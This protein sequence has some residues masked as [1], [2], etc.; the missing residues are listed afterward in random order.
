MRR[1]VNHISF[2][3]IAL[4]L[5]QGCGSQNNNNTQGNTQAN[6]RDPIVQQSQKDTVVLK[7]TTDNNIPVANSTSNSPATFSDN[8]ITVIYA[9]SQ[10]WHGGIKGSGGGTN[11]EICVVPSFSSAQLTIDQLWIDEKFH[12]IS[13]GRRFPETSADGFVAGDTVYISTSVYTK[14][15]GSTKLAEEADV[16]KET[17]DIMQNTPTPIK[18]TGEALIGYKINGKRKYKEIAKITVKKP[19]YYP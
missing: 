4:M 3:F 14:G 1:F 15:P 10:K 16:Q 2:F 12:E 11:Y 13:A 6:L 8:D 18:F 19:L 9:T 5:L 7:E 17:Q